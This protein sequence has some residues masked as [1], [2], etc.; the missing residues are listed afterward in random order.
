MEAYF[1]PARQRLGEILVSHGICGCAA[2]HDACDIARA[3]NRRLGA[4]LVEAEQISENDLVAALAEQYDASPL[5]TL[6]G[7]RLSPDVRNI[8]P[9]ETAL[10]HKS[11]LFDLTENSMSIASYDPA[12]SGFFNVIVTAR[13]RFITPYIMPYSLFMWAVIQTYQESSLTRPDQ[14]DTL[15]LMVKSAIPD[16]IRKAVM[17]YLV[18]SSRTIIFGNGCFS[19]NDGKIGL[20]TLGIIDSAW[21]FGAIE[22]TAD[23]TVTVCGEPLPFRYDTRRL[24]RK[25]EDVLRKSTCSRDVMLLAALLGAEIE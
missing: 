8:L 20:H 22:I 13:K 10:L 6:T 23:G 7:H 5:F 24:R 21:M 4:V 1:L 3:S 14:L 17:R 18:N 25:V 2:V 19:T 12:A 15:N 16:S 11:L 9:L